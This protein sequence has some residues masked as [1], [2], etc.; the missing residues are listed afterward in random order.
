[1]RRLDDANITVYDA[2]YDVCCVNLAHVFPSQPSTFIIDGLDTAG[3]SCS[4]RLP[5]CIAQ[6]VVSCP[7]KLCRWTIFAVG[8][9]IIGKQSDMEIV[10]TNRKLWFTSRHSQYKYSDRHR[11]TQPPPSPRSPIKWLIS[12]NSMVILLSRARCN[13]LW[14]ISSMATCLIN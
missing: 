12:I 4:A 6:S 11:V 9:R 8:C 13:R 2:V 10:R 5:S 14:H 1:M 7:V 3:H